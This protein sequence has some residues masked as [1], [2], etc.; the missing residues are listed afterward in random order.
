MGSYTNVQNKIIQN[1]D[2]FFRG[3]LSPPYHFLSLSRFA[4]L[5]NNSWRSN[6]LSHLFLFHIIFS[7]SIMTYQSNR[8]NF[9]FGMLESG[10][11]SYHVTSLY[12]HRYDCMNSEM[13]ELICICFTYISERNIFYF[14]FTSI[15]IFYYGLHLNLNSFFSDLFYLVY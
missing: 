15:L 11:N 10:M 9:F 1:I 7:H 2:I 4:T 6:D 8:K 12:L 14:H 5:H 13:L 3:G